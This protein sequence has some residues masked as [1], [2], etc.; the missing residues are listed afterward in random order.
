MRT[1]KEGHSELIYV[2][3][4]DRPTTA[5]KA[6]DLAKEAMVLDGTGYKNL[7]ILAWD[8]DY[9]FT[10]E[11]ESLKKRSNI[12][13]EVQTLTIPPEIYNYLKKAKNEDELEDLKDKLIFHEKPYLKVSHTLTDMGTNQVINLSLD[14]YVLMAFPVKDEKQQAELRK[15]I[16]DN[17]AALIDYWAV[18]WDYDGI[19]FKSMWQAIRGYGKRAE[20]VI[21]TAT[22]PELP[23]GKRAIAVRLVDIFGNDASAVFEVK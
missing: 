21:T 12:K 4:P 19:T 7:V 13:T 1:D 8:Y 23:K 15:I 22:S 16:K 14:R 6:I 2:G 17:F 11:F 10:G 18:D 5:K 3:Y 9:N 20:T